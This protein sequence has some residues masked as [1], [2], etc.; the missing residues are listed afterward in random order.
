MRVEFQERLLKERLDPRMVA[1]RVAFVLDGPDGLGR[2]LY[3]F[4]VYKGSGC[5]SDIKK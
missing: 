2:R 3:E 1:I 5:V 4:Y